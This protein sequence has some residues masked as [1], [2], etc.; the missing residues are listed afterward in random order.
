M[1]SASLTII[2]SII[3]TVLAVGFG[4]AALIMRGFSGIRADMRAH[5]A[6]SAADR[7][8]FQAGMDTY[9]ADMQRLTERHDSE[10]LGLAERQ[11]HVEGRIDERGGVAAD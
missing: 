7:R 4:L 1:D 2:G 11:S 10:M 5:I 6:E 8:A 3:G 9:R